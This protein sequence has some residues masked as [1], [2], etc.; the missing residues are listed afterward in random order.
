MILVFILVVAAAIAGLL[1]GGSL[2]TLANTKF[3]WIP[4]LFGAL[5][6]QLGFDLW[7]PPWL[8]DSG[9]LAVLLASHAAVA[10]FFGLNWKLPGMALAAAG[11]V[12]NVLVIGANGAMPISERA[13]EAAG[14]ENFDQFGI[15]HERLDDGTALPWLADVIPLPGTGKV[16]S[17]GDVLLAAG[18]GWLVYRRTTSD[19]EESEAAIPAPASD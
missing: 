15:K 8:G 12:L 3:R 16:I 2:D 13:A 1:R 14:L 5:V 11:F 18:I 17:A 10:L 7:D 19:R 6:L 9:G 4:V